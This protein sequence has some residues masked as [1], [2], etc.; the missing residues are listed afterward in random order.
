MADIT[1]AAVKALR[2]ITDLPMMTCKK[3]L[4]QAEGDQDKAIAILKEEVGKVREKRADNA[5]EEGFIFSKV[6]D[7][8]SAA[9]MVE[10]LCESAPVATGKDLADFGAQLTE[11]LMNGP[12]AATAEEL[13][14]QP[15]PGTDQTLQE[16]FDSIV[17]KI[18][19]KIIVGRITKQE[20]PV[21]SY[22]HHNG[23]IAVLFK[24]S[25]EKLNMDVMRDVAM[26]IAAMNPTVCSESDVDPAA[27]K[28]YRAQLTE[29]AKASGKPE[30]IIEKMVDGRMK[31]FYVEQGVLVA[32][33]F[34][35][36][37]SKTVSQALAEG[38]LTADSFT[39]W[40]LGN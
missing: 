29:E 8:G 16:I 17:N 39:L 37:D 2:E 9:V 3:A 1:A 21:A 33:A 4:V 15:A 32:Q 30:N 40:V 34:A 25:G 36:D 31:N 19:E 14:A 20:G 7:D 10:V 11:Q 27:V 18:R 28:E 22:V 23:K 13:L 5:T 26:H 12:G 6:N 24:A 35:K 38:G